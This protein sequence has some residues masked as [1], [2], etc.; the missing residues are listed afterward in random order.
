MTPEQEKKK[1]KFLRLRQKKQ[2]EDR[3]RKEAELEKKRKRDEKLREKEILRKM[4]QERLR[5]DDQE[6]V[7]IEQEM[8]TKEAQAT[9]VADPQGT[10]RRQGP[11]QQAYDVSGDANGYIG[12]GHQQPS[13]FAEFSGQ[14]FITVAI[15]I[16]GNTCKLVFFLKSSCSYQAELRICT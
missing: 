2:E 15:L 8:R 3:T 10:Y 5:Q 14:Y 6:R 13:G 7:R 4:E 16:L 9:R 12:Q 11:W 1:E